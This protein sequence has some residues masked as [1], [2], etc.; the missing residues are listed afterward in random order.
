[1]ARHLKRMRRIYAA[2]RE[3]FRQLCESELDGRLSLLS[4]ET[5]IQVAGVLAAGL[6]D[7]RVVEAGRRLDLNLSPLSR[8]FRHGNAAQGL[9]LGYAACDETLM[10]KGLRK[11]RT[12]IEL[13]RRG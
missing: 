2:R 9:V 1:M 8:H 4:G 13:S 6:D 7:H 10:V 11:L 3:T 12:A 5:G